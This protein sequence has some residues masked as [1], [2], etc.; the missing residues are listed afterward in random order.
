MDYYPN[1]AKLAG[2]RYKE[3]FYAPRYIK[4]EPITFMFSNIE[5]DDG[6]MFNMAPIDYQALTT[7]IPALDGKQS[8]LLK[9]NKYAKKRPIGFLICCISFLWYST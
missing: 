4:E 9:K 1:Q 3:D 6:S 8:Y 5:L 7:G 2:N